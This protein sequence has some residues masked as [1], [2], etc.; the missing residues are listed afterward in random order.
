MKKCPNC[1]KQRLIKNGRHFRGS[2]VTQEYKCNFCGKYTSEP[3]VVPDIDVEEKQKALDINRI[4]RKR[5]RKEARE[6]YSTKDY[7]ECIID[8]LERMKPEPKNFDFIKSNDKDRNPIGIIHISDSHFL[9]KIDTG[10]NKFNFEIA[11]K[12]MMKLYLEATEYFETLGVINVLIAITGDMIDLENHMDKKIGNSHN[13]AVGTVLAFQIL[14]KFMLDLSVNYNVSCACVIGNEGRITEKNVWKKDV[15]TNNYDWMLFNMLALY[16]DGIVRF[17]KSNVLEDVVKVGD[18]NI[19]LLHGHSISGNG[20][21]EKTIQEIIGKYAMNG[22]I[23]H[24][25]LFAHKH[26]ANISD[27]F[28]RG[29]S[30]CGNDSYAHNALHL[31]GKA[32]QNVFII[33]GNKTIDSIRIDLQNVEDIIGYQ[34]QESFLEEFEVS[35]DE[36]VL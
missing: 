28:A 3:I 20:K 6:S 7:S 1:G 4:Y 9:S 21:I 24:Y 15:A 17:K 18:M 36:E 27:F 8:L 16:L 32:S 2:I 33:K 19:L 13:R 31:N 11:S 23:I 22:K 30:L 25:V 29:A 35:F 14:S 26:T 5:K 12:R 10:G 34:L